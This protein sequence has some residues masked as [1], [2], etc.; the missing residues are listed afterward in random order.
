MHIK[1]HLERVIKNDKNLNKTK[2][3]HYIYLRQ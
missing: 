1:M 2:K 3:K